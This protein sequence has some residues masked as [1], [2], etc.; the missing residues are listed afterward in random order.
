MADTVL[1]YTLQPDAQAQSKLQQQFAQFERNLRF[2]SP[3]SGMNKDVSSFNY[4][5]DR[6]TQ[7][8]ITLGTAFQILTTSTRILRDVVKSTV[9]VE[10]SLTNINAIFK[11]TD[12]SLSSFGANLFDIARDTGKSFTDVAKAAELFSHQGLTAMETL[13]RT[14]DAL[15]L[16][17]DANIDVEESAKG[18]TAAINSFNKE[19]LTSSQVINRIATADANF[20]VSSKDIIEAITRTG[21]AMSDAGVSFNQ[22]ISLV[23]AAKQISQ[24]DGSV[25]AQAFNT[26]FTR[27]QRK[28]VLD[29]LNAIGVQVT[30][31][32]GKLLPPLQVLQ[33][34]SREYDKMTGA[35][36]NQAAEAVGGVRNLNILKATIDD[37][38][39]SNSV[40][41]QSLQYVSNAQDEAYKRN[42]YRNQ[43][44]AAMGNQFAETGRQIGANVGNLGFSNNVK[45][46]G[47][48]LLN[49]PI[50][51]AL[52]N[53]GN[54]EDDSFGAEAGR[55][56]LKGFGN[57][58]TFGLT[59]LLISLVG[60]VAKR[61]FGNLA[62]DLEAVTGLGQK[63]REQKAI[64][65]EINALYMQ[66][67][68]AL[69]AQLRTMTGLAEQAALIRRELISVGGGLG[70]TSEM[71]AV[72]QAGGYRPRPRA[73]EGYIPIGAEA[74]AIAA[75]VGGAPVG[76][77]PVYLPS[78]ARGGGQFGIVANTSEWIAGGTI[79]NRDMI[80]QMG[81][82]P[83]A[84]PVAAGG[85]MPN[86]AGGSFGFGDL[87]QATGA[88]L[89]KSGVQELN[90]LFETVAGA[91][92]ATEARQL[93]KQVIDFSMGLN[94]LSRDR[95]ME[96]LGR[97]FETFD[98]GLNRVAIKTRMIAG[99]M[100]S[101]GE[102]NVF[103]GDPLG[104]SDA[105][106]STLPQA[107]RMRDV[108]AYTRYLNRRYRRT[109]PMY[110]PNNLGPTF[111]GP[112][113]PPGWGPDGVPF[114]PPVLPRSSWWQRMGTRLNSPM[115]SL[116]LAL[117]LPAIGANIPQGAA[118]TGSG[119][120]L[121]G[122]AGGLNYAGMGASAGMLFGNPLLGAGIGGALGVLD[123]VVS[124]LT[125]S[126]KDLGEEVERRRN[127]YSRESNAVSTIYSLQS[128]KRDAQRRGATPEQIAQLTQKQIEAFGDL[129]PEIKNSV[130]SRLNDPNGLDYNLGRLNQQNAASMMGMDVREASALMGGG[131]T[132][133]LLRDLPGGEFG[134][135]DVEGAAPFLRS[136]INKLSPT[137]LKALQNLAKNDPQTA[138][139]TLAKMSG[140]EG[141]GLQQAMQ[142]FGIG[143]LFGNVNVRRTFSIGGLF[144]GGLS[145]LSMLGRF[146]K[147]VT[148]NTND[149]FSRTIQQ[150]ILNAG[151]GGTQALASQLGVDNLGP[152]ALT[153]P[154]ITAQ[155]EEMRKTA[156]LTQLMA[157]SVIKLSQVSNRIALE[158]PALTD[159]EKL[160]LT[161]RFGGQEIQQQYE[162]AR[163]Y[164]F[165]A[166]LSGLVGSLGNNKDIT[167]GT[168]DQIKG[169]SDVKGL[170]T[171]LDQLT[172]NDASKRAQGTGL[173]GLSNDTAFVKGLTDLIRSMEV[174]DKTNEENKDV[175]ERTNKLLEQ[176]LL[177]RKTMA[178]ALKEDEGR[179]KTAQENL[180]SAINR[181][182]SPTT[183]AN[184]QGDVNVTLAMEAARKGYIEV[185]GQKIPYS[186]ANLD[187]FTTKERLERNQR[188]T[189]DTENAVLALAREG[190]PLVSGS[191]VS[192]ALFG[193]AQ[194]A[195]SNGDSLGSLSGGFTSVFAG[196]KQDIGDF[197]SV[198]RSLAETLNNNLGNAF[199]NFATGAQ[200]AGAAF[201]GFVVSVLSDASRM[202]ASKAI[203]TLLSS[204]FGGFG[205]SSGGEATS[206]GFHFAYGGKVPAMVMG[207]EIYIG[208]RTARQIGYDRLR[209][210]NSSQGL[211]AGGMADISMI[212]GGSGQRDDIPAN[213]PQ[214]AFIVR[215]SVAQRLGP[216]YF[217]ALARNRVEHHFLGEIIGGLFGGATSGAISGAVIGAGIGYLSGGKKGAIGGAIIGAIGGG[218]YGYNNGLA[219]SIGSMSSSAEIGAI[220]GGGLS[221]TTKALLTL[222]AAGGLG[223]L[224]AGMTDT[225]GFKPMNASQI[226]AYRQNL[227]GAQASQIGSH[228]GQNPYVLVGPQGQNYIAGYGDAPATRRWAD[229][230]G[231]DV[232]LTLSSDTQKAP[233]VNI[234]VDINNN[235][236][237]TTSATS[238]NGDGPFGTQFADK[239]NRNIRAVVQDELVR[240]SRSDGF[241]SQKSRY[242]NNA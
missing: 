72:L 202:L 133:N 112:S 16:A 223:L 36:K 98:K 34:F 30:D 19:M 42:A 136:V 90:R 232:P 18:M 211:A 31:L 231:V 200:K 199:G 201:K 9:D 78:F 2:A 109:D 44:L 228:L 67:G 204:A 193:R 111:Y 127:A 184:A 129:S 64:E 93:G 73:A 182:E 218:L 198:G 25:I 87:R 75:G 60:S 239:L 92:S 63:A 190:N 183:I 26:M 37:L 66:G 181:N 74:A 168:I 24:R 54:L 167:Q 171:L 147:N 14:R 113:M 52:K 110:D 120:L 33:N 101:S 1:T 70:S 119:M 39:K 28:D 233:N 76:A 164:Q 99:A 169:I 188:S 13:K 236:A 50:T 197:S 86:A 22:F 159:V 180:V 128:D 65:Q 114:A 166:G 12:K 179:F 178:G 148:P 191:D 106:V 242:V 135:K 186:Y 108:N 172:S 176:Q 170:Q 139:L 215:K 58:V 102:P 140:L 35:L 156:Q 29:T 144:G 142:P 194:R 177:E 115:G 56:F 187:R 134:Q 205:G 126:M 225:P 11:L 96:S 20:A 121:G 174:L 208:P 97:Q 107:A 229:G 224:A 206:G 234:K 10:K 94:Q 209:R 80:R 143:Q 21:S 160:Q 238:N 195:G 91:A 45:Q 158:S 146:G 69:Q 235:G 162:A 131:K 47:D 125:V 189:I 118:G 130:L 240:Q 68:E 153:S 15:I 138:M 227:E 85:Y 203:T 40:Y 88:P 100:G 222:G 152:A 49:N 83:G 7:R 32:K 3:F 216:N 104:S 81:L 82:P 210:I 157:N 154:Q 161:G 221:G 8:V 116:A 226:T 214:G 46:V 241:F 71:A 175:N 213:L 149:I 137:Q 61:V 151:P 165:S 192:G 77:R 132:L 23:T 117:G 185:G 62:G 6:A 220:G 17:R 230:G 51:N 219:A 4:Q 141:E 123:G 217:N 43:T 173:A 207:G 145:P 150:A 55:A 237:A 38:S 103:I 41:A 105:N 155:A 124:K 53:A 57:A 79:Y 59:P 48:I 27:L 212:R 196:L 89:S 5:L 163:M 95:V 84:T 122:L